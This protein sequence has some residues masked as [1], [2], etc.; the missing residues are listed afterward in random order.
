V[1]LAALVQLETQAQQDHKVFK[2]LLAQPVIQ[3]Q[4]VLQDR[5]VFKASLGRQATLVQRELQDQQVRK[6]FRA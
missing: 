3:A 6:A 5:K 2:V 4:L 1:P